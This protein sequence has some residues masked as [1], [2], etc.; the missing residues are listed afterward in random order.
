MKKLNYK[1]ILIL[2]L[3]GM[4][5]F[6]ISNEIVLADT[7]Y[8]AEFEFGNTYHPLLEFYIYVFYCIVQ[9][10]SFKASFSEA[11]VA[12]VALMFIVFLF[13]ELL[14]I[15]KSPYRIDKKDKTEREK[16]I[17]NTKKIASYKYPVIYE[18]DI[19]KVYPEF[20]KKEFL[21]MARKYYIDFQ[22][23]ITKFNYNKIK[24]ITSNELY[25]TCKT[26]L[27]SLKKDNLTNVISDIEISWIDFT[28]IEKNANKID[29]SVMFYTYQKNYIIN[30]K[31]KIVEGFYDRGKCE[32][33]VTF[34]KEINNDKWIISDITLTKRI[35][36]I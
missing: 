35:N 31:N 11:I 2:I 21:N 28:K 27:E 5:I 20:N 33:L 7:M 25:N 17:E 22:E 24:S 15:T 3:F 36:Y 23:S 13:Y 16:E 8:T 14:K 4:I 1:K 26:K 29:I 32:Y 34:S 9:L 12:I 19:I 6:L 10:F 18:E 30:D